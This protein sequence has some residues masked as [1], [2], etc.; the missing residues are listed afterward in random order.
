VLHVEVFMGGASTWSAISF[1]GSLG[2][3][4]YVVAG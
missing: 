1:G 2:L 3:L 4:V